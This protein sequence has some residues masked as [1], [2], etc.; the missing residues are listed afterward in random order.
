MAAVGVGRAVGG[1][2]GGGVRVGRGGGFGAGVGCSVGAVVADVVEGVR[3]GVGLEVGVGVKVWDG[4]DV[5]TCAS[6]AIGV[7]AGATSVGDDAGGFDC[8]LSM[9]FTSPRGG[10]DGAGRGMVAIR[11]RAPATTKP[12]TMPTIDR[13]DFDSTTT[14][15]QLVGGP[16]LAYAQVF[17]SGRRDP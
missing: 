8:R 14:A 4:S 10:T 7:I 5:A 1:G 13:E 15:P 9:V 12:T 11:T 16:S 3:V 2:V 17:Q 6:G